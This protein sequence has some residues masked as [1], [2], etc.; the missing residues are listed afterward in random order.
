MHESNKQVPTSFSTLKTVF[1]GESGIP[2]ENATMVVMDVPLDR[3]E[4][5][6]ILPLGFW[7]TNPPMATIFVANYPIFPFGVPYREVVMM[8]HVRTPLGRGIHCNWILVDDDVALIGGRDFLGYPKKLGEI[9]FAEN[10]GTIS[11]SAKRRGVELMSLEARRKEPED[12]PGPVFRHK[13][14]NV[15]GPGQMVTLTP[16]LFFYPRETIHESFIA[17]AELVLKDSVFDP[18]ARLV[19]GDPVRARIVRMDILLP[20]QY[21]FPAGIS[22]GWRWFLNTFN[23]RYR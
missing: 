4:V 8:I 16:V 18:V 23:M 1:L 7:P 22:G 15:G 13:N 3:R 19:A 17:Q 6:R 14:F 11:A 21:I 10:D 12:N 9:T 5:K 2:F 20:P